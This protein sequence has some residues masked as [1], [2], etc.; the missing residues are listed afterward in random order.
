MS[1]SNVASAKGSC[2]PLPST[3]CTCFSAP[4]CATLRWPWRIIASVRSTPTTRAPGARR[5]LQRD[6]GGA[7]G[8]VEDAAAARPGRC[9]RPWPGASGRSG[10]ATATPPGGR[11]GRGDRRTGDGRTGCCGRRWGACRGARCDNPTERPSMSE[12]SWSWSTS[13][14]RWWGRGRPAASPPWSWR[15]PAPAWRSWTRRRSPGTR[16][17]ATQWGPAASPCSTTW[18]STPEDT[19]A[20]LGD[21]VVVGPSGSTSSTAVFRRDRLPRLRRRRPAPGVRRVVGRRGA[22]GRGADG[23]GP[24]GAPSPEGDGGPTV[25]A[26]AR[27]RPTD[28]GRRRDRCR[29]G[30][31]PSGRGGRPRR[32]PPRAVG[33]RG[34]GLPR[35]ARRPPAHR[36]VGA[37]ARPRLPRLRLV[38]P[39]SRRARQRRARHRHH[40]GPARRRRAPCACCP[41]F[42]EHLRRTRSGRRARRRVGSGA[43]RRLAE[44]GHGRHHPRGRDACCSPATPRGS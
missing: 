18:G 7:R 24:G 17:A 4:A 12:V 27:R 8:D 33:V 3:T 43:A 35:R 37:R 32:H 14:W 34:A 30:H 20:R 29:R 38:V 31:E 11:S 15:G 36:A 5:Q 42:L 22:R 13:T 28:R 21:M 9:G 10:R 25:R 16:P 6:P 41:Q 26:R 1:A 23:D 19:G 44:D 39:G 40:G 2:S